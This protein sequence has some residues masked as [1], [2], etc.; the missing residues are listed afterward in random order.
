MSGVQAAVHTE[1]GKNQ[2][3]VEQTRVKRYWPGKAPDWAGQEEDDEPL[4]THEG[5]E[6]NH[7]NVAAPVIVKKADDPR[8]QR[9]AA[10]RGTAAEVV[11]CQRQDSSDEED[12]DVAA[13]RRRRHREEEEEEGDRAGQAGDTVREDGA[14]R[15]RR[16]QAEDEA[17]GESSEDE[18]E[19]SGDEEDEE[20]I[21]MRRQMLR[22]KLQERR[23]KEAEPAADG[24]QEDEGEESE[25]ESEYETD[26]D[27]E[28]AGR[29][30]LKP[31]FVSKSDRETIKE[32]ERLE[33]EAIAAAEAAAA[34]AEER[35]ME[36]RDLVID[37]IRQE[38]EAENKQ[39]SKA[40]LEIDTD[41]DED[42]EAE[43]EAWKQRELSRIKR[44]RD[45][46]EA[47]E[48]EAAEKERLRNMTEEERA[49][50]NLANPKVKP[51]KQV[52]KWNFMQK[53]WHKGAYFQ[54]A[55]DGKDRTG[56]DEIFRRDFSG[57]TGEDKM[58]KAMLP[59][60]MQVKNFGRS[61]RSKWTHL[62][63]EDTTQLQDQERMST[64]LSKHARTTA[65]EEFSRPKKLRT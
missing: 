1:K 62:V 40:N 58:D 38:V 37:T 8:L 29:Q 22:A 4:V 16:L 19:G 57:P 12:D 42:E 33:A 27:D 2:G 45:A 48:K 10:A 13:R 59:K 46:K 7:T 63:N 18:E 50:W 20:A 51:E 52:K 60:V 65:P 41:D 55:T 3:R 49:A 17:E 64:T 9:L 24:A 43:F 6:Q 31:V 61:G 36:T 11:R 32:K 28:D 23:Q 5:K 30:M 14:A 15:A 39:P 34:R 25:E 21:A 26:S 44:D 56:V 47:A 53:Y 35:K 54:E